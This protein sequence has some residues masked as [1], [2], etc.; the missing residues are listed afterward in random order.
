MLVL[1]LMLPVSESQKMKRDEFQTF[2]FVGFLNRRQLEAAIQAQYPDL[3]ESQKSFIHNDLDQVENLMTKTSSDITADLV[4][5]S[6]GENDMQAFNDWMQICMKRAKEWELEPKNQDMLTE[7]DEE[8]EPTRRN[9][10]VNTDG[11]LQGF[12]DF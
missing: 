2:L 4:T 10:Y 5:V 6:C 7:E 12:E 1:M 11:S 3:T 8:S 9:D